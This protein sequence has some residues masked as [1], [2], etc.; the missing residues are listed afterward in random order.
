MCLDLNINQLI[1]GLAT[2][3]QYLGHSCFM[4]IV[5]GKNILFDPFITPNPKASE[6][7]VESLSPDVII[8]S[9]GHGDHI[10]DA[11]AI[12]KR[13]KALVISSFEITEWLSTKG[14]E[15]TIPM[16]TGGE[17]D[18]GS[19]K[20]KLVKAE[21]SSSLPDGAYGGNPLGIVVWNNDVC[22]YYAGD[23][24]LTLDMKL[25]PMKFN[26][27]FCFL[28]VG[29]HFTM[30]FEDAAMAANMVKCNNVIGMHFDTFPPIEIDHDQA[31][32]TFAKENIKLTLPTINQILEY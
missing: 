25:I 4:V 19:C 23:T 21:H 9:H 6:I 32:Q 10:A 7:D 27:D 1:K 12:A 3:I 26:L 17:F 15:N 5:G 8:I 11:E 31:I 16:N 22:F 30:G 14:V 18:L 24:S 13:S 28:P 20:I 29:D 2:Q